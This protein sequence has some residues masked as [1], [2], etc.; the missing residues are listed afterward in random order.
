MKSSLN[1]HHKKKK[2]WPALILA[3]GLAFSGA[4]A[5]AQQRTITVSEAIELGTSNSNVLK[6]SQ[7]RVNEAIERFNQTR[8]EALPKAS[9]SLMFNHAEFLTD[10]FRLPGSSNTVKLPSSANAYIGTVTV[11]QL[12]FGGNRLKYAKE[13]T[14]L[15]SRIARSEASRQKEDITFAIVNNCYNLYRIQQSQKII[16]QN[17]ESVDRQLKQA[18]QFFKE[19]VVTKND[20]LRY[21]LQHNNVELTGLD[22]EANRKV[23]NYN[24]DVLLGLPENT[25]LL[26]SGFTAGSG[27]VK[28][29]ASLIDTALS[30]REELKQAA[31]RKQLAETNT[32]SIRAAL[33]PTIGVGGNLYYI[34]PSTNP[35]PA[36]KSVLAPVAIAA[37]ANW[38][39]DK[40]WTS[41]SKIAEAKIQEREAELSGRI[42]TDNIKTEVNRDLQLYLKSIDRIRI[43]E[44]SIE[45]AR[46][47]DRI[48]ESKYKNNIA[49]VTDR[50][51]AETQLYKS[52]INLELAKDDAGLAY[53]TLLKS[54]GTL[55]SK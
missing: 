5:L 10:A 15:L 52:L 16:R 42:V 48:M 7:E 49:S 38:N 29:P 1:N 45:Q 31:I 6:L 19:G 46:E 33:L 37:S 11:E 34:D 39:I 35:F 27:P 21:Q 40:L 28:T 18:E 25:E 47:N 55:S 17:L 9:A 51:D 32:R 44:S 20:V 23:V 8:D 12:I 24:L 30:T 36:N 53:Y 22:L 50:I 43:L 41:K 4:D 54:T 3:V 26:I 2:T 14:D 13:S